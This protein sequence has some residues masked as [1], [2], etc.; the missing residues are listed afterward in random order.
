M[1]RVTLLAA[2]LAVVGLLGSAAYAFVVPST[3]VQGPPGSVTL[4][5]TQ[6]VPAADQGKVCEVVLVTTN[7]SSVRSGSDLLVSSASTFV[8]ADVEAQT[9]SRTYVGS[10]TLGAS[11]TVSVRLGPD[12]EYSGGAHVVDVNCPTPPVVT[13]PPTPPSP[14]VP[15]SPAPPVPV[16]AAPRLTG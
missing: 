14:V 3:N 12:G 16:P 5:T 13:T 6:P 7:N 10:L 9:T 11:V 2:A 4:L 8:A 15:A 1:K